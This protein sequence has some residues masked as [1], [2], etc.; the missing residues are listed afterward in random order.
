MQIHEHGCVN[1]NPTIDISSAIIPVTAACMNESIHRGAGERILIF[2]NQKS[3][4]TAFGGGGQKHALIKKTVKH[5]ANYRYTQIHYIA[6]IR[7]FQIPISN[8]GDNY[9]RIIYVVNPGS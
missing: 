4:A 5:I 6:S 1:L 8:T 2:E 3:V 7:R 9:I